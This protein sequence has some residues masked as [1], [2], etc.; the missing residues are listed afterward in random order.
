V[1]APPD[2]NPQTTAIT[3]QSIYA[4]GPARGVTNARVPALV[5]YSS[6]AA[7]FSVTGISQDSNPADGDF[8]GGANSYSAAALAAAGLVPGGTVRTPD[9]L[10]Y[11]WPDVAPGQPDNALGSGQTVLVAGKPGATRLGLLAA[12]TGGGGYG[13]ITVHYTDGPSGI[14]LVYLNDWTGGPN[15]G[16]PDQG[17][18][19]VAALAYRNTASGKQDTANYLY[20]ATIAI[21]PTRTVAA[22]TLPNRSDTLN[23]TVNAAHIFAVTTGIPVLFPSLAAAFNNGGISDDSAVTAADFDGAGYSYSAQALTA[24][25]LAPGATVVHDGLSFTWPGV[26]AGQ[27]DNVIAMG[28]TIAVRGAGSRLGFLG[29]T[30]PNTVIGTGVVHYAD[31]TAS[32]YSFRLDDYWYAPGAENDAVVTLPYV[33]RAGSGRYE[34]D[35]YVFYASVPVI[36]GRE[37]SAVT[38]PPNGANPPVGR[39]Q[40]MHIFALAVG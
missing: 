18:T 30:S 6:L 33:N 28:Q 26:P 16:G 5:P 19:T 40:G 24:A 25:G 10:E 14:K 17:F 2:G 31:G 4:A 27:P 7:S 29:A 35:V 3:V 39:T 20:A 23:T 12:C 1:T 37:V 34:H 11:T 15:A 38:L 36:P 8:D 13:T 32:E 9:G 21:D 22:I